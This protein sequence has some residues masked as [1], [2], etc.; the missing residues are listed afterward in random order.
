MYIIHLLCKSYVQSDF[1]FF[2]CRKALWVI[3]FFSCNR[4]LAMATDDIPGAVK[5]LINTQKD[6][7][8]L[9]FI[10]MANENGNTTTQQ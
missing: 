9:H 5:R 3:L 1:N 7:Y 4:A 2:V 8:A 10:N 6:I